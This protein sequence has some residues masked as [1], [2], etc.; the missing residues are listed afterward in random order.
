[1]GYK[2]VNQ[3][4][5]RTKVKRGLPGWKDN[6]TYPEILAGPGGEVPPPRPDKL[7]ETKKAITSWLSELSYPGNKIYW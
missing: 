2:K 3:M 5:N 4:R 6:S 7:H 1:M